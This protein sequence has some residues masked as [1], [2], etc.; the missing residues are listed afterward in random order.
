MISDIA[1]KYRSNRLANKLY[2]F[3]PKFFQTIIYSVY[4]LFK[5]LE[6]DNIYKNKLLDYDIEENLSINDIE[7]YQ[8]NSLKLIL[9]HARNHTRYYKNLFKELRFNPDNLSSIKDI[10][11]L[12]IMDKNTFINN[13][14]DLISDNHNKYQPRIM[15]SGGTTGTTLKFLMDKKTYIRNESQAI[16]YWKRHGYK[17][18]ECKTIIYRSG[19]LI[20]QYQKIV[21][22]WRFDYGRKMLY[23]SSYYA[24]ENLYKEYYDLLK[25]WKP[26]Y[27]QLIPSAA[28]LFAKFLNE[29]SLTLDLSKAFSGSE[30]LHDFQKVEI[31]KAFN[32][33]VIDHYGH[34][35]PGIYVSGQCAKGNYHIY[36]NDVIAEVMED[37]SLIETSLHNKSMPFIRYKVGDLVGGIHY[38][39][40]C[41]IKT[42]YFNK[43]NGRESSIIYA[44]D[45]RIISSSGFDQIFRE[46]NIR[47]AQIVQNKKGFLILNLVLD[48]QFCE[49]D[50]T[51]IILR[52]QDRVGSDTKIQIN[53]LDDIPKEKSGKYNLVKSNIK[54]EDIKS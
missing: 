14:N 27:M 31:E 26:I 29:N 1:R 8:L 19:V 16:H 44:A 42:P 15:S 6:S 45:G 38:E 25:K 2:S 4:G 18:G 24:S 52:I 13:F 5:K 7:K 51:N 36:T 12:P 10:K 30:M 41:G 33:K 20:S 32:C 22:P 39:C 35:E 50:K 48:K 53:Y 40:D 23:L 54:K 43:I 37:G 17:V 9:V 34:T 49:T 46:S 11:K 47:L 21:K 3:T 28:Y